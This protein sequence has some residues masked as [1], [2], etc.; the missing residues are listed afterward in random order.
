[1]YLWCLK[2][3]NEKRRISYTI[4]VES[5]QEITNEITRDRTSEQTRNKQRS[6]HHACSGVLL[7]LNIYPLSAKVDWQE[8]GRILMGYHF[9]KLFIASV[10]SLNAQVNW[11]ISLTDTN[12][13]DA[14][15]KVRCYL[16]FHFHGGEKKAITLT[17]QRQ[18]A[19][20]QSDDN[21]IW[22]KKQWWRYS[23]D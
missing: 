2:E 12:R 5:A 6:H 15:R 22:S 3:N 1:M 8:A 13:L 19:R 23:W 10:R 16:Q 9:Q 20:S 4:C 7:V 21:F 11:P 17:Y 18:A 14:R